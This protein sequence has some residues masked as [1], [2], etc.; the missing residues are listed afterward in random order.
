MTTHITGFPEVNIALLGA[1]GVGKSALTVKYIT[2]RFISEYDPDLED[3]YCK[4]E[5]LDH[6]EVIVRLMDTCD[7]E[8]REPGR[9]LKWADSFFVVYSITSRPTF[10]YAQRYLDLIIQNQRNGGNPECSLVLIGNKVDLERYSASPS[11]SNNYTLKDSLTSK[12]TRGCHL[13]RKV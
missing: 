10:E 7:K 6:Q 11:W 9:Y 4:I 13:R 8:R 5:V 2:K 12:Q 3:T 1:L